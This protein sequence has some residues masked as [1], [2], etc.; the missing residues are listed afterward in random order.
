VVGLLGS[1]GLGLFGGIW[2]VE[3]GL[4]TRGNILLDL[5]GGTGAQTEP[6]TVPEESTDCEGEEDEGANYGACKST[7]TDPTRGAG[8]RVGFISY[9]SYGSTSVAVPGKEMR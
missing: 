2:T 8:G 7:L 6:A 4:C 5:V 9:A 3:D 1:G